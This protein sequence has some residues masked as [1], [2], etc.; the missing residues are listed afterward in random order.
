M[1]VIFAVAPPPTG[2]PT[3]TPSHTPTPTPTSTPT[4]TLTPTRTPLPN[5]APY[6]PT[7][8]SP[9]DTSWHPRMPELC[10]RNDGDIN[11]DPV[12]FWVDLTGAAKE[13]SGWITDT[14]WTPSVGVVGAYRW[15]VQAKD[16]HDA[17]SDYSSERSFTVFN[18]P[19]NT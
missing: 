12:W 9:A 1:D 14:C 13:G 5:L 19:P 17:M 6:V 18:S 11:G 7:P 4:S 16:N 8:V 2:T 3:P 10:W 15:R